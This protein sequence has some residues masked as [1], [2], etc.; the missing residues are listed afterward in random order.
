MITKKKTKTIRKDNDIENGNDNDN[1]NDDGK[2][3]FTSLSSLNSR[4]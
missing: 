4:E 2:I 1:D 3:G